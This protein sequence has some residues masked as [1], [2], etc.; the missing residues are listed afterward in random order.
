MT[1]TE[2][3]TTSLSDAPNPD[4]A[5]PQAARRR[6]FETQCL[7]YQ[8][9]LF[10]AAM[11]MTRQ[12]DDAHDL[13]QE[14][15]MRA[16]AAWPDLRHRSNVRAWLFRILSNTFINNY[17]RRQRHGRLARERPN[18]TVS[19]LYGD[20]HA[21]ASTPE[22]LLLQR[23]LG[24]EVQAALGQLEPN[25]RTILEMADLQDLRYRDIAKK[26]RVPMGTVMSRLFRARRKLEKAL[27]SFA[28]TDY[29]IRRAA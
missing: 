12:R 20:L 10:A 28:A 15:Y 29:G 5:F 7:P 2:A 11:R 4:G 16:L 23:A 17:R 13:V 24:D 22:E 14:T 21:Q 8:S 1:A 19:A 3:H 27:A 18:E 25:Y 9:A 26:L 6:D